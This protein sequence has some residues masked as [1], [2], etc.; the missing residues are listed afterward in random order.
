MR[1]MLLFVM[2]MLISSGVQAAQYV[3]RK[4]E[5]VRGLTHL[6]GHTSYALRVMNPWLPADTEKHLPSNSTIIYIS[7]DDIACAQQY[8]R[9]LS[10]SLPNK[11]REPWQ[12][13]VDDLEEQGVYGVHFLPKTPG[14]TY[15]QV[16]AYARLWHQAHPPLESSSDPV[17][18]GSFYFIDL[19]LII[20]YN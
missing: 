1:K 19:L 3:T 2:A 17:V 11:E 4:D 13:I 10:A 6:L 8:I 15:R 20:Y 7:Q 12:A 5:T 16:L 9:Q 18:T 14:I